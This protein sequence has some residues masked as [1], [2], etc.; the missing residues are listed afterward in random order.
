[1]I[2]EELE[3]R[4]FT[5]QV[6]QVDSVDEAFGVVT[7]EVDTTKGPRRFLVRNLKDSSYTLGRSRV[8]MTDV[9]GKRYE[10]PDARALGPKALLILSKIM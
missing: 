5:P 8:M 10:F 4:Y 6:T 3:R 9:D 7:W 2:E 1:M